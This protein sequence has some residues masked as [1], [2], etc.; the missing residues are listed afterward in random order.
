MSGSTTW[1][2]WNEVSFFQGPLKAPGSKAATMTC[3]FTAVVLRQLQELLMELLP[4]TASSTRTW[5]NQ[6]VTLVQRLG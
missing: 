6:L 1:L 2:Q 5:V 4:C 3:R